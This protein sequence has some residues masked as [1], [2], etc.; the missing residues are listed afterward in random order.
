[1]RV[2]GLKVT[3]ETLV[4]YSIVTPVWPLVTGLKTVRGYSILLPI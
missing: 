3:Y 4:V 1:M 2:L